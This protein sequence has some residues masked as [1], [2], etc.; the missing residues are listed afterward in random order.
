[1]RVIKG[2]TRSLDDRS[3]EIMQVQFRE[4]TAKLN[5]KLFLCAVYARVVYVRGWR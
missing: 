2:D 4:S 3:H 1:M 5:Q